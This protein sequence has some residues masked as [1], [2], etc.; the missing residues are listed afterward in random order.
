MTLFIPTVTSLFA[1]SFE[2][3][4]PDFKP[5]WNLDLF[6]SSGSAQNYTQ[7]LCFFKAS[8]VR[9]LGGFGSG[10]DSSFEL[11]SRAMARQ[12]ACANSPYSAGFGACSSNQCGC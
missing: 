7:D 10:L 6:L 9:E 5:D 2:R 8:L 12:R 11:I 1:P 4:A 3:A